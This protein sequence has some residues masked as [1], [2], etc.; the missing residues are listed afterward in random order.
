[1]EVIAINWLLNFV[2]GLI[3]GG[4]L[5]AAATITYYRK[6]FFQKV[7]GVEKRGGTGGD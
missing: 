6:G 3:V 2:I 1:L 4:I 5:A 7:P